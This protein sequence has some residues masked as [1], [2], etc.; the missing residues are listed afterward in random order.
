MRPQD[1]SSIFQFPHVPPFL[2]PTDNVVDLILYA[3]TGLVVICYFGDGAASEGDAHAAFNFAA[4]LDC[5]ILF[6]CRFDPL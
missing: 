5:P 4:T 1:G 6:F 2:L 3:E